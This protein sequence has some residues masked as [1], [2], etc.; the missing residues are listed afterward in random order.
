MKKQQIALIEGWG[1][2][3][4][5]I[6]LFSVKLWVGII[7]GS[8]ALMADAW[9]TLSDSFTSIVIV[10]SAKVSGKPAD[11]EHPFGHGRIELIASVIIGVLLGV[12]GLSFLTEAF[13]KISAKN[14]VVYPL[15]AFVVVIISVVV[16][17]ASAQFA[18]WAH[19]KTGINALKADG[20]HHRSDALS[21]LVILAGITLGRSFWWSDSVLGILVSFF[22]FYTAWEILKEGVNPLLGQTPDKKI[23]KQV[24]DISKEVCSCCRHIHHVHIHTY[25]NHTEL[26]FHMRLDPRMSIREGHNQTTLLEKAILER[27]SIHATIHIEPDDYFDGSEDGV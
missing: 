24:E 8:I 13:D 20:A 27:L 4:V 5:N 18:F 22:I 9:H 2:I 16:K 1:S 17:E 25:G 11:K 12:T 19:R 3:T 14:E 6:L 15:S 23:L 21:S 7:S 10:V 26:T